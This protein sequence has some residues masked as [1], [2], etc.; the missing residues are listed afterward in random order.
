MKKVVVL[1]CVLLLVA[2]GEKKDA[3]PIEKQPTTNGEA[4][5][6]IADNWT[7]DKETYVVPA[8]EVTVHLKNNEGFHGI[9]IE[10]TDIAIEGDGYYTTTLKP[11]E[12]TIIC[13]VI[14][15]TGHYDI[16]ATLVVEG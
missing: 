4:V 14:C 9:A 3:I 15:G 13:N 8:G 1:L 11:G 2:C 5:K 12:Y 10:G 7:F 16:I 6:I